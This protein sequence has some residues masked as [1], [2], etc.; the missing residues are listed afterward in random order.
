MKPA[1]FLFT[2]LI[3]TVAFAGIGTGKITG[4]I[5]YSSGGNEMF[6]IKVENLSD[7]PTCNVTT[8]FTMKSDNPAYKGTY[9]AVLAAL[10]SGMTVK[11]TGHNTCNN[12]SNSEDLRYICLGNTPC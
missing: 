5:P 3:S 10:M 7:T 6:F 12:F 9:A 4:I 1:I 2:M 8:R 11:A